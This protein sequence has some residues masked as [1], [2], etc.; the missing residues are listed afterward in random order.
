MNS[1]KQ[2]AAAVASTA[3][4]AIVLVACRIVSFGLAEPLPASKTAE[5]FTDV[6]QEAGITW[7]HFSGQSDD[8]FL[9][10]TMGGGVAFIDFDNDGLLDLLF[11]NGGETPKGK[12]ATPVRNA[13]Y[14]N[15][16]NGKFQDVA[17]AAGLDRLAFYG[18]GVAAADYDNDGFPDIFITG[19]PSS[20]LYHNNRN[21]TF[22]DV[23]ERA[24][25][26]NAGKWATCAVWFDYDRDGKLDLFVCNYVKFSYADQKRCEFDRKRGYCE[27]VAYEG[28]SPTLYHNNG[29]G[30]FT[31][32]SVRAGF[33]TLSRRALGAVSIDV[34]D[35]GWPDLFVACDGSP[36]L[37]LVNKGNGTFEDRAL[38]AEVAYS[39][40]GKAR[41]GMG[42][43]AGDIN[44]DGWPDFVVTNFND[45]LHALF[46]HTGQLLF[47]DRSRESGLA[48]STRHYVGFGTKFLDFDN[49]GD[50][51]LVIVN[52]HVNE[53][54]QR[55]RKDIRYDEPPLLLSNTG[56]GTF[57]NME[58]LAGQAFRKA[59]V[60]R[61]LAVGDF[62]NDGYPDVAFVTLNDEPVL[63]RNNL[64]SNHWLGVQLQGKRSNR[65][66][67]GAK[68][69][70][71]AGQKALVR[72]ITGG[73]SYL[74]SH[75]NRV[76]FGLGA[77][78]PHDLSLEV[79]WPSGIPQTVSNLGL[80]R[81]NKVEEAEAA[82]GTPAHLGNLD[83][84]TRAEEGQHN[85]GHPFA[86]APFLSAR[87]LPRLLRK[88]VAVVVEAL[89][90]GLNLYKGAM[91][92][93]SG[94]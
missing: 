47:E 2:M 89:S 25:V 14:R 11:V 85:S 39:S 91:L 75:D 66:A 36:N 17:A 63:L 71:H 48:A 22:T 13:L 51:D 90:W 58:E 52:G 81:Y 72:W 88:Q 15:L 69:T 9:L 68:L 4:V 41:A 73:S 65:D 83:S 20:A 35:D 12:S 44:G 59:Y 60:A 53:F 40:E 37:L 82:G 80:D 23:T 93:T 29:D 92:V 79:R 6:T 50:L 54:M 86:I 77:T 46:V 49:D 21:G 3:S 57:K 32:V 26:R 87:A 31:N 8:R 33:Q 94:R 45:E 30:T 16:G 19:Y 78:L 24:G 27:Q 70:L 10:E 18:M 28:D 64:R 74:A 1:K 34:N 84:G 76:V 62:N 7:R 42:V 67:I 55:I 38:D 5:I 61:G 43:D 56:A